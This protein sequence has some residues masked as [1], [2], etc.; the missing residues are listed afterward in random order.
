MS[1]YGLGIAQAAEEI[2]E[3]RISSVELVTDCLKRNAE[4]DPNVQAWAHLDPDHALAQ[5]KALDDARAHGKATG[6][7]H[8]VPVGIKDVF[9]T[10][11]YPTELGSKIWAGRTPRHDAAAVAMLRAA[12][13][14]IMGK[15]VSTEYAFYNPGKTRNP[16]DPSRTPGGSSSGSAAAVAAGAV[17]GAIGSQTNGSVIRPASFCGVVGFK[18][19]HGMI[20]R[21]G[22][23]LLSR[24]LDHVGVFA[25]SVQDAAL[26]AQ[27]MFGFDREDPD[28]RPV[29]RHP[30]FETAKS[31]PPLPPRFAFVKTAVWDQTDQVTKEAFGE[32]VEALGENATEVELGQSHESAF[33]FMRTVMDVEMAHNL[34]RDYEQSASAMSPVLRELIERGRNHKAIDYAN[35]LGS[36][37]VLRDSLDEIFN[38]FDAII[39]PA[40]IGVAPPLETTGNPIFCSLWT[41]LGVPAVSV[42][43]MSDEAGLPIGV[44]I[45]GR[46]GNDARLLRSA[47]WLVQTL[48]AK[49]K[50]SRK[51]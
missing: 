6:P 40:A 13:A 46:F 3:G 5:A 41:Y 22:A 4:V 34:R 37:G 7:L 23:L 33:G 36:I 31:K 26:L 2:R 42:P 39:T 16:Y 30:L 43:L 14:V 1:L 27:T 20:P 49:P 19:S 18:P 45:V 10:A 32:L 9:D 29:A 12:G 25:R 48:G 50:R 44:Q 28:T 51:R 47:N 38:E 11:D 35:A 8:G 17:P 15:T 24:A 21:S